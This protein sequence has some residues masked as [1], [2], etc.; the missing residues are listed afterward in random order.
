MVQVLNDLRKTLKLEPVLMEELA[1]DIFEG[2]FSP[3]FFKHS[4]LAISALK[5]TMYGDYY[6]FDK[7]PMEITSKNVMKLL[8]ERA[9]NTGHSWTAI[10]GSLIEEFQILSTHNLYVIFEEVKIINVK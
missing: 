1:V 8:E 5:N 10:N 9:N 7:L 6:G 3:K 2:N 4:N